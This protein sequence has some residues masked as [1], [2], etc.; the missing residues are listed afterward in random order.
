MPERGPDGITDMLMA[1]SLA[2]GLLFALVAF[3]KLTLSAM[4][5]T[6]VA[7]LGLGVLGAVALL[8]WKRS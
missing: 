5:A 1:A 4:V 8:Q 2:L 7:G 3:I 6:F